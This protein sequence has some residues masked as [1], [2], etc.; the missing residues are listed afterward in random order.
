MNI[1]KTNPNTNPN[2]IKFHKTQLQLYHNISVC[3]LQGMPLDS[4]C[5]SNMVVTELHR[6]YQIARPTAQI[7]HTKLQHIP[8]RLP[9]SRSLLFSAQNDVKAPTTPIVRIRPFHATKVDISSQKKNNTAEMA[10]DTPKKTPS[11]INRGGVSVFLVS[12]SERGT[13]S[14]SSLE[15]K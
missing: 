2:F 7:T 10:N 3:S 11:L 5:F 8:I 13:G 6:L 1:R 14:S 4:S 12:K 9:Q 15:S